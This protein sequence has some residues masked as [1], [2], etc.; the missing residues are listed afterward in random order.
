MIKVDEFYYYNTEHYHP[1][2][3]DSDS[4]P[5]GFI[6]AENMCLR[7]EMHFLPNIRAGC[8]SYDMTSRQ[9]RPLP[10]ILISWIAHKV[11]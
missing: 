6:G 4:P 8:E 1:S 11:L 9:L 2:A 10:R 5:A 3:G 7:Y